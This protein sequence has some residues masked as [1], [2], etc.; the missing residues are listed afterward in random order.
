LEIHGDSLTNLLQSA[1]P[2]SEWLPWI[3]EQSM[4]G[5]W[6]DMENQRRYC[7]WLAEKLNIGYIEDWYK[8]SP[9]DLIDHSGES[10]G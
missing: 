8:I 2:E 3:Y 9:K 4:I 10:M 5:Y 7:D 6:D 1:Y